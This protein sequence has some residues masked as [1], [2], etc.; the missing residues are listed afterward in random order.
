MNKKIEWNK[1]FSINNYTL[2]K[3]HELI[4]DITNHANELAKEVLEHYDDSL[5]E[6][7]KKIIIRLFD[8]IKIHFKDEEAYMK[9]I[10]YPLLE[11]HKEAHRVL[12]E[13]TKELLNHSKNPQTFAKELASLTR[14]WISKHFCVDD[15]WIDAY[16]YRAIHLNEVH[17]SLKTY[18]TIQTL[19]N[20]AIDQEECFK[21]LCM[22]EDKIHQMP[23]SIHEELLKEE[24]VLKCEVCEQILVLWEEGEIKDLSYLEKEFIKIGKNDV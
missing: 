4:F 5:Q 6:E 9:E 10:D 12:V 17:F 3:Q 1:E 11:E 13:K 24:S 8:Y 20:P 7:L 14:D 23:K 22:C 18:K 15:K 2:D 16:K 19:R 21:Y